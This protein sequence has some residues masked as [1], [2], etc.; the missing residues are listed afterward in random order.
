MHNNFLNCPS[1]CA[2]C[3]L[4]RLPRL[5]R[6]YLRRGKGTDLFEVLEQK[7]GSRAFLPQEL[8]QSMSQCTMLFNERGCACQTK[9]GSRHESWAPI[10]RISWQAEENAVKREERN[11][12]NHVSC[13]Q[14]GTETEPALSSPPARH[15]LLSF[16]GNSKGI[17]F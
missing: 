10:Q 12:H 13:A 3:T 2:F 16:R 4:E 7:V 1:S 6:K 14:H 11:A 8:Q 5:R 17:G 15:A 9:A